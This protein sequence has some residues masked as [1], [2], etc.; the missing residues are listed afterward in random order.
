M[1]NT[2][3]TGDLIASGTITADNLVTGTLDT[4]LNSYLTTNTYAT[5]S[6]VTTAVNNLIDAAP[7][8]LDTLN[9]LAAA[10]NDDANFATTVTNSL[11]TKLNLSG[12][13][14]TG[15][16]IVNT[17]VGIGTSSP[18]RILH[19]SGDLVRFD[20]QG[21]SAVLLLDRLNGKGYRIVS[22]GAN[23][24]AFSIEDMGS[25]TGGAGTER[26][27]IDSIGNV[28]ITGNNNNAANNTGILQIKDIDTGAQSN[29]LI[30]DLQFYGS[31]GS[32]L[33]VG[34]KGSIGTYYDGSNGYANLRIAT[35]G[36]DGNNIERIRITSSGNVGIGTS[37][38]SERLEVNGNIELSA[39]ENAVQWQ[40][41]NGIVQAPNSLY[42]RTSGAGGNLI[43]QVNNSTKMS[44]A[45]SGNVGIGCMEKR[46]SI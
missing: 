15:D 41:G 43:F 31:D 40:T 46:R 30:G 6:Y 7:A 21:T 23:E 35:S 26:M 9:E 37:S 11:A 32:N 38:P 18:D 27:R 44:I 19:T 2:K 25:S 20:N 28:T 10:L 42:I 45:E 22:N 8:S 29:Q 3:V 13:T 34:V 12:G 4:L 33:G 5:Q 36:A 1:A 14:L 24:G 16:L 17:N 39:S